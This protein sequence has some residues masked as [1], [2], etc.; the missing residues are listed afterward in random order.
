MTEFLITVVNETVYTNKTLQK[1]TDRVN[2]LGESIKKNWFEIAFIV[3]AVDQSEC[4]KEDG[5]N[6]VHEWVEKSFGIKKTASYSLLTIGKEYTRQ[7]MNA[8]GKIIGY[9]S[10]LVPAGADDFSKTQIEKMLPAGHEKAAE[11]VREHEVT[12][13]M[14]AKEIAKVVQK[15]TKPQEESAEEETA[16]QT[17]AQE[18]DKPLILVYDD[19]GGTYLVPEDTLAQYK[20]KKEVNAIEKN[21]VLL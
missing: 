20:I 17:T 13:D 8:A 9:G 4:Y 3:A 16:E 12:P 21:T 6:T 14:T 7:N 1:A 18:S 19:F 5:F 2:R 10:N 15:H 11:L